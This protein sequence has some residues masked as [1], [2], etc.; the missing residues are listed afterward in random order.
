MAVCVFACGYR[1]RVLPKFSVLSD[2]LPDNSVRKL[3]ALLLKHVFQI[4]KSLLDYIIL[5]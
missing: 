3:D 1:Q 4:I 2:A 5:D